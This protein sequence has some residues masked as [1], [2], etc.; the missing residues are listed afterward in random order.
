MD[1]DCPAGQMCTSSHI[2]GDPCTLSGKSY[3]F[4]ADDQGFTHA[5][6]SGIAGDDP[7]VRGFPSAPACHGGMN[8]WA[9]NLS[10]AGYLDCQT[11]ELVSPVIDLSACAGLP[12][13]I[14]LSFWHY[15]EFEPQSMNRWYDGG[16]LQLSADGGMT[17]TDVTT[18]QPYEGLIDGDYQTCTPVPDI[19]GHQG[20]SGTIPGGMWVQVTVDLA[21][22][23]RV[24]GF[25]I[26]WLFG[27]DGGLTDRGWLIDDVAVTP[28]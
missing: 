26:R 15:Y 25:R 14:T 28:N 9:T 12:D 20:W 18:S 7:W 6:T 3:D 19:G 2:C 10:I 8:C 21:A 4:E 11:A 16:V 23:Y 13:P 27:A 5:P 24:S 1:T 17:W 22:M